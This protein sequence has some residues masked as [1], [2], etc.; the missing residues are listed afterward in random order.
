MHGENAEKRGRWDKEWWGRRP[1][2]NYPI[3]YRSRTNKFFKRLLHKIER[4][5]NKKKCQ[6]ND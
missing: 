2:A 4:R 5:E 6:N 1:L 3:S